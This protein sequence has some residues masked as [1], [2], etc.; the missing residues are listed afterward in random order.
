MAKICE[1]FALEMYLCLS[2]HKSIRLFGFTLT[3][4]LVLSMLLK[5]LHYS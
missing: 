1:Y 4:G 3:F 2:V 5:T